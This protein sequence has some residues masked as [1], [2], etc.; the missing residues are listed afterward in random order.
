M[1]KTYLK[2]KIK[3][4]DLK[5][6]MIVGWFSDGWNECEGTMINDE[7]GE[8]TIIKYRSI[9]IQLGNKPEYCMVDN[10]VLYFEKSKLELNK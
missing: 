6:G 5:E 1:L 9:T 4:K 2:S 7:Y 8:A 3:S 10:S